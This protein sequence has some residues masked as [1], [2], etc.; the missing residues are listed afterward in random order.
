MREVLGEFVLT[1]RHCE[2]SWRGKTKK[3]ED[4]FIRYSVELSLPAIPLKKNIY[5]EIFKPSHH[6][7]SKCR[8]WCCTLPGPPLD[9][10]CWHIR[11]FFDWILV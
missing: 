6:P 10:D 5:I 4:Y 11:K 8:L 1:E 7:Y 2:S 3:R 9:L